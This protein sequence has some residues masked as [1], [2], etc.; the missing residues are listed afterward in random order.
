MATKPG[1]TIA[2]DNKEL[3]TLQIRMGEL[4]ER[5]ENIITSTPK[6][7]LEIN[8]IQILLPNLVAKKGETISNEMN[9]LQA[10]MELLEQYTIIIRGLLASYLPFNVELWHKTVQFLP[11]KSRSILVSNLSHGKLQCWSLRRPT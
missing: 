1:K 3:E 11:K 10:T 6:L 4:L 2:R 8:T 5:I 9:L 7:L